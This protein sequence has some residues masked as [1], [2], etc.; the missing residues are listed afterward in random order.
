MLQF[1][2]TV[3][4]AANDTTSS[5]P[6]VALVSC[7]EPEAMFGAVMMSNA[8]TTINS[9]SMT[10]STSMSN[11][12]SNTNVTSSSTLLPDVFALAADLNAVALIFYSELQE[13]KLGLCIDEAMP[14][15]G[16]QYHCRHA[17][18]TFRTS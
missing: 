12:T 13:V 5:I 3:G 16:C 1:N 4:L 2:Q 15:D 9:T 10:N 11:A 6:F 14:A 7:D 17:R 8:S 18:S